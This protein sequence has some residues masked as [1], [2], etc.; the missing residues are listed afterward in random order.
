LGS[1]NKKRKKPI[2][3]FTDNTVVLFNNFVDKINTLLDNHLKKMREVQITQAGLLDFGDFFEI[4][5]DKDAA[6]E[7]YP[8]DFYDEFQK[9]SSEKKSKK[10][11]KKDIEK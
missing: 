9:M 4:Q 5:Y 7:V 11:I 10:D 3:V 1:F 8:M 2:G 6:G